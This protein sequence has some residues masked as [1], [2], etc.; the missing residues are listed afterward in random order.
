M[1]RPLLTVLVG[2][3]GAVD[4]GVPGTRELTDHVVAHLTK[5]WGCLS[6][7]FDRRD[8][9]ATWKRGKVLADRLIDQARR[10]HGDK[11]NFENLLNILEA[12]ATL[13]DSHARGR[14]TADALL[15]EPKDWVKEL[16]DGTF[17]KSAAHE[18]HCA[19]HAALAKA[20]DKDRVQAKGPWPA[21]QRLWMDLAG[22]TELTSVTLNYD[23]LI[24]QALNLGPDAQG[25][26]RIDGEDL[27]QFDDRLTGRTPTVVHLHGS[28]HLGY[29]RSALDPDPLRW[30]YTHKDLFWYSDPAQAYSS[31]GSND[32]ENH[33]QAERTAIGGPIITGLQKPDKLLVEPYSTYY[34]RFGRQLAEVPRLLVVGYGFDDPHVNQ[35]LYGMRRRHGDALRIAVITKFDP[36]AMHGTYGSWADERANENDMI[37]RWSTRWGPFGGLS[38]RAYPWDSKNGVRVYYRGLADI[39]DD[40]WEDLLRFLLT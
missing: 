13:E 8:P 34:C 40:G 27:W 2:A 26:S 16:L 4:L 19:I 1:A 22:Q 20:S 36:V 33:T 37:A 29:R 14:K 23:T 11:F 31:W 39:L 17:T 10:Y 18:V 32:Q 3:G 35:L 28:I 5:D 24:E 15:L 9:D 38:L 12:L 21:F 25:F 7:T 30:R 6:R